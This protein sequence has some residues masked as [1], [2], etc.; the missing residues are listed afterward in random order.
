MKRII[1][2]DKAPN[3]VGPYSQAVEVNGVLYLAGQVAINPVT[4]K[5][6][7]GGIR[8]QTEQVMKNT[9]AILSEAGY[10]YEDVVK[11]TCVLEEMDDFTAMNEIYG[12]YFTEDPPAR[13]VYGSTKLP[14]GARI[15]IDT[16]AAK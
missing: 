10:S 14:L 7:D 1:L 11:C 12:S 6:V 5:I 15:M 2:T 3:P 8:E 9:G 4:G 13:A 16:I